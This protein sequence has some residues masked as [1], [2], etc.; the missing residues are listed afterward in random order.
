MRMC[1]CVCVYECVSEY[2]CMC[3]Y[4]FTTVNFIYLFS[5]KLKVDDDDDMKELEQWAT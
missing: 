2:E 5:E 4:K 3:C 1:V